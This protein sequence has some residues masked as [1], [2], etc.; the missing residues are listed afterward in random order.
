MWG[1]LSDERTDLSFTMAPVVRHRSHSRV[2]VPWD[3]LPYFTVSDSRL[4][5]S[6]PPT[7]RRAPVELF[8]PA[9]TLE[10]LI[11]FIVWSQSQ[12]HIATDGQS[13]SNSCC[14]AP[15]GA[16]DQIFITLWQLRSC[17]C[18][19]PSLTREQACLLYMLLPLASVA[20]LGSE[21]LWTRDNI[22]LSQIWDFP[23]QECASRS[24]S[25][26]YVTTDG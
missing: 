14:R 16:H 9:S 23:P 25:Q 7:T 18:G 12:S 4:L 20:F 22:L 19:A 5:F 21:S 3:S 24:Q 15:C 11:Y 6:S 10:C 1:T 26:S 8:D 13:I 2:R 17:F